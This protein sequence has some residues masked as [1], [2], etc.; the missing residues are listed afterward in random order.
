MHIHILGICGTFM[1]G[2]AAIARQAGFRVTGSDRQVYPP[3]SDQ[4]RALDIEVI[5]GF[6]IEQLDLKPDLIVIGNVM[7]RGMPIIEKILNRK[8]AFCS[9]PQWLYDYVLKDRHVI[10]VSGTHGK[11]TT[12]SMVT[13]ILEHAGYDPGYLVG[14]VPANFDVSARLGA[15]PFF[16]IEADEYDT[17]FFNKQAKF[18]NYRP[19]T[20]IINNIEFD[21][22]DIYRDLDAIL[23]QFHQ[24]LRMLPGNGNC[25]VRSDDAN[26][27]RLLDSGC[28]TPVTGFSAQGRAQG[29]FAQ[30][31]SDRLVFDL[32]G[33]PQGSCYWPHPGEYNIENALAALAAAGV[34]VQAA[35]DGLG[36]FRGVK[37]R[38]ELLGDFG[39]VR[40]Y[41]DFAHHPTAIRRSL[42]GMQRFS[43]GRVLAVLEPR[44]N[45][46]K[47]GTHADQLSAALSPADSCWVLQPESI[48][49]QLADV[50]SPALQA[51]IEDST[52]AIVA[53]VTAV[54]APG[55]AIVIMSNGSFNGIYQDFRSALVEKFATG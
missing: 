50:L 25:V 9:G 7:S 15:A 30:I 3:M 26:I 13:W 32:A 39:G 41:D 38:M 36:T 46:M 53:A 49:W 21:H 33:E 20:L 27:S 45:T 18:L 4:L 43:S 14:G 6:G 28:W 55:D 51:H 37:R 12:T 29:W 11:T 24:L 5:E 47:M 17:A 35:L 23:W 22:A 44:S 54:A 19:T 10:A 42:E 8:L 40:L 16:V 48:D 1:G 2:I 31:E 34:P 52:A